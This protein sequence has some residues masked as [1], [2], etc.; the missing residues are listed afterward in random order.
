M[1]L[2]PLLILV[3]LKLLSLYQQG[4]YNDILDTRYKSYGDATK[5]TVVLIPGLDGATAFFSDIVPELTVDKHVVVFNLPLC[6]SNQTEGTYTFSYLAAELKSVLDELKIPKAVVVGESFGGVVAQYLALEHPAY[7][8]KLVLL[9]SLAKA[10][11][12]PTVQFKLDYLMPVI[13]VVGSYF[14]AL[15]QLFFA[16]VHLEDVVEPQESQYVKTLFVKEAS[17]A[18]FFSVLQRIRIVTKLDLLPRLPQITH[19]TR[20]VYGADDHFTKDQS[21]ELHRL[22]PNSELLSLPGGHLAHVTSPKEFASIILTFMDPPHV[23]VAPVTPVTPVATA[24]ISEETV[25]PST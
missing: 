21:L 9:S 8:R 4:T 20:V 3:A 11:L 6:A 24:L 13:A 18:H 7:V 12:P 17:F 1:R 14:P 22:L 5:E 10:D 16:Q 15:A 19:P 2:V 23:P 25:T